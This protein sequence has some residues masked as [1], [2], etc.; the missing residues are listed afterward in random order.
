MRTNDARNAR[1]ERHGEPGEPFGWEMVMP[2]NSYGPSN[3]IA[4]QN[5]PQPLGTS[6]DPVPLSEGRWPIRPLSKALSE[7]RQYRGDQWDGEGMSFFRDLLLV[8]EREG[9]VQRAL[10]DPATAPT[11]RFGVPGDEPLSRAEEQSGGVEG[12]IK[13]LS[14]AGAQVDRQVRAL[15]PHILPSFEEQRALTTTTG[16][17]FIPANGA[18]VYVA[19]L[20][21]DLAR[22]KARLATELL[23][24]ELPPFGMVVQVGRFSTGAAMAVQAA[25]ANA[26]T[27]VDPVGLFAV[28]DIAL[29]QGEV[30]MSRQLFDRGVNVDEQL[31]A[32]LGASFGA[33]L[34]AQVINGSGT[35]GQLQ[36]LLGVS[37]ITANTIATTTLVTVAPAVFKLAS[38]TASAYGNP[39]DALVMHPRRR[40]WLQDAHDATATGVFGAPVFTQRIIETG[41]MPTTLGGGTEDAILALQPSETPVFIS[42][43]SFAVLEERASGTGQVVLQ[44][45]SYVALAASRQPT[46]IGKLTGAGLVAPTFA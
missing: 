16:A 22:S 4:L 25:E 21:A 45:R 3:P 13:R 2:D 26:A 27:S 30:T 10:N 19:S 44:A 39:I 36:G 18:P 34:E 38:D 46:S 5:P 31:A 33:A 1:A 14:A 7:A 43:P 37:G 41:G 29:I 17:A 42:P 32:S 35:A 40:Q 24:G 15:R 28:D 20:F 8:A 6:G 23:Q 12:A 9:R 11:A